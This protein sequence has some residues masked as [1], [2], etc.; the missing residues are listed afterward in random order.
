[1]TQKKRK[2]G[3]AA[4]KK[5]EEIS[6]EF[7]KIAE[8]EDKLAELDRKI[9]T[10]DRKIKTIDRFSKNLSNHGWKNID[11][12][13]IVQNCLIAAR[14]G[15]EFDSL[16]DFYRVEGEYGRLTFD[17][18]R[19]VVSYSLWGEKSEDPWYIKDHFDGRLYFRYSF[20]PLKGCERFAKKVAKDRLDI[21]GIFENDEGGFYVDWEKRT[22]YLEKMAE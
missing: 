3:N 16:T 17:Q 1:M 5:P 14:N 7:N 13:E 2:D 4:N 9:N 8:V 11:A 18:A 6:E 19:P 15:K 21:W 12:G 20:G 22:R 10:M